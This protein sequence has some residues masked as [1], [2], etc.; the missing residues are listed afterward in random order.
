MN[1]K[2][3]LLSALFSLVFLNCIYAGNHIHSQSQSDN[4]RTYNNKKKTD[5]NMNYNF[6]LIDQKRN[7]H[8]A[9]DDDD[10]KSLHFHFQRFARHKMKILFSL[11]GK[12]ILLLAHISSLVIPFLQYLH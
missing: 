12:F 3:L 11:S 9:N 1:T 6:D 4:S 8:K 5:T 2:F 10:G 7:E